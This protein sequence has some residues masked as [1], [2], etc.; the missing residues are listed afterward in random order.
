MESFWT[1][2]N[3]LAGLNDFDVPK[4]HQY[5]VKEV[6]SRRP[7]N[8]LGA[9]RTSM[10]NAI[11][12]TGADDFTL[13]GR[14]GSTIT[15]PIDG[16]VQFEATLKKTAATSDDVRVL[17]LTGAGRAFCCPTNCRV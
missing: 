11:V 13:A 12:Y 4:P 7:D 15:M 6:G 9:Q 8:L 10:A 1:S 3:D 16:T 2:A 14:P 5:I 17:V